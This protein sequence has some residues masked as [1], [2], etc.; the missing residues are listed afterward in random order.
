MSLSAGV[1][2]GPYQILAPIGAGG[3]GEVWKARDTRL[4]R[5]VA[6]KVLPSE[7]SGDQQH[8]ERLLREARA[9][10]NLNH[11]HICTLHDIGAENGIDYLVLEYL[12]GQTLQ[13]RL[14][15]GP[16]PLDEALRHGI[17]IADALDRAHRNQVV[18]RD[19]KPANIMLT[20][21]GA[22]VL[23][24]GLA[25][26]AAAVRSVHGDATLTEALTSPGVV[27]G[28]LQYMAPEQIEG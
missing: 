23:D 9:V 19:L 8:R 6:I 3:M 16:L 22:K 20:R 4:D 17:E 11:P 27:V 14:R 5:T 10:S 18:H 2:L 12:D 13:Q 28:T 1:R 25:K 21:S 26:T 7:L 24:F 15:E